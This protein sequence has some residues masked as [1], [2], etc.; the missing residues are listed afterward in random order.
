[1]WFSKP[2]NRKAAI[3]V[4]IAIYFKQGSKK[5]QSFQNIWLASQNG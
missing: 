4:A 2:G 3:V 1:M 5:L